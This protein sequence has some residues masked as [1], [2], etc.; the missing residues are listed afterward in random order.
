MADNIYRICINEKFSITRMT[1]ITIGMCYS[2][3]LFNQFTQRSDRKSSKRNKYIRL[4]ISL[5]SLKYLV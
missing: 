2:N 3:T 5:T 1:D 4:Y